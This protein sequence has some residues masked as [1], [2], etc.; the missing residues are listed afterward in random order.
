MAD[1]PA[2]KKQSYLTVSETMLSLKDIYNIA[3]FQSPTFFLMNAFV[4]G[5][6]LL[7]RLWSQLQDKVPLLPVIFLKALLT[8]VSE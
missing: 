3:L 2:P 4:I 1:K 7:M 6:L 5:L 8:V